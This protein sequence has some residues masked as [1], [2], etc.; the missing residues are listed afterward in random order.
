MISMA[1]ACNP[2]VLIAD[3]PTTAL[4]VTIQAQVLR[5]LETLKREFQM[6]II[7]ITH[8]MGVVS[9]LADR[10]MVMYGGMC[11]EENVAEVFFDRPIHPYTRG[12][13]DCIPTIATDSAR[14]TNIPGTVP[15]L[16]DMPSGCRF[17]TRCGLMTQRCQEEIPAV[18]TAEQYHYV[19]CFAC[20]EGRRNE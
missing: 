16:K 6:S 9:N 3:E 10:I 4:D 7:F 1:L 18:T 2:K 8:D 5:L 11:M 14:L 13:L 12:L 19:R 17:S 20:E 15:S